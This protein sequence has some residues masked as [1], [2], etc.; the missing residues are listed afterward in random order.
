M[1]DNGA[2][3]SRFR[4]A[5]FIEGLEDK[6]PPVCFT[7]VTHLPLAGPGPFRP[8]PFLATMPLYF[9]KRGENPALDTL[10]AWHLNHERHSVKATLY[11]QSG[12][13]LTNVRCS[14]VAMVDFTIDKLS[15]H[16]EAS[17]NDSRANAIITF[18]CHGAVEVDYP[19]D[20][21]PCLPQHD[22]VNTLG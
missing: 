18:V 19:T 9:K 6:L 12:Y 20:D 2:Y 16:A 11:N 14:S 1:S 8:G 21:Q 13:A 10:R 22:D 15:Y 4:W 5:L 17:E 7:S 3:A